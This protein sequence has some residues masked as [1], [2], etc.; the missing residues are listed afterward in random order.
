[1][2]IETKKNV[3]ELLAKAG[4]EYR[5]TRDGLMREGDA[6]DGWVHDAWTISLWR[7]GEAFTMTTKYKTG[8]GHRENKAG[9][10]PP[11]MPRFYKLQDA[12]NWL[13]GFNGAKNGPYRAKTPNVASVISSLLMDM[14]GAEMSFRS[15]C[16]NYGYDNDSITAFKTYQACDKIA[17]DMNKVFKRSELEELRT[18]LED[19]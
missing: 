9:N 8:I 13:E 6:A 5:A 4:I 16:D 14:D 17:Q 19:F 12:E 11:T 7:R 15:W 3:S 10:S 1:M 2:T 18:M